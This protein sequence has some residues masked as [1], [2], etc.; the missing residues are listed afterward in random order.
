MLQDFHIMKYMAW[1][2]YEYV[3]ESTK[4]QEKLVA[5]KKEKQ[6]LLQKTHEMETQ[7]H[8]SKEALAKH[9]LEEEVNNSSLSSISSQDK[10]VGSFEKHTRGI[11][12]KL[13]IKMGYEG[14][15]LGKHAQGIVEPIMVEERPKY[16]GLGYGQLYGESSKVV[17]A[18]ETVPRRNF[19]V[20][21]NPQTHKFYNQDDCNFLKPML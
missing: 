20:G 11:G 15:G 5:M 13:M 14:K 3:G 4:I 1:H 10:C 16:L 21:S 17:K 9:V 6:E 12:S 18:L 7:L 8:D 2:L 19:V